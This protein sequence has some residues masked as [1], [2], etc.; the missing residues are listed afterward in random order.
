ME[1]GESSSSQ[2]ETFSL[3]V[4]RR[5]QRCSSH[6]SALISKAGPSFPI[7]GSYPNAVR[8]CALTALASNAKLDHIQGFCRRANPAFGPLMII[9]FRRRCVRGTASIK[10]RGR[11]LFSTISNLIVNDQTPR[12][13]KFYGAEQSRS[14][15]PSQC[16]C[17]L[18]TAASPPPRPAR[19]WPRFAV[20]RDPRTRASTPSR[21]DAATPAVAVAALTATAFSASPRHAQNQRQFD[22][23]L[24]PKKDA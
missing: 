1:G 17:G 8:H 15:P 22:P 11:V 4:K 5:C 3:G 21:A 9:I 6:R 12:A 24:A 19:H 2:T 16:A 23:A 20:Q 18:A 14:R 7:A 10:Q 13:L